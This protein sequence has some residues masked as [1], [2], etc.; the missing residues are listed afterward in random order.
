MFNDKI[1]HSGPCSEISNGK[2]P[3]WWGGGVRLA[4]VAHVPVSSV[5]SRKTLQ[6]FGIGGLSES[7]GSFSSMT[8][9]PFQVLISN[10]SFHPELGH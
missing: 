8:F 7:L 6:T 4:D 3:D 9:G 1:L 10:L 5:R 2:R